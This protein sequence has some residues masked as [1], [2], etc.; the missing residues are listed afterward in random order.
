MA[1]SATIAVQRNDAWNTIGV[2]VDSDAQYRGR[3]VSITVGEGVG[4]AVRQC[5]TILQCIDRWVGIV[6]RVG[7][8][9]IAVQHQRAIGQ[10]WAGRSDRRG[11][12][13][14]ANGIIRQD[15]ACDSVG[16]RIFGNR[17]VVAHCSGRAIND[18][19]GQC[20]GIGA[21]TQ[22]IDYQSY[23][24]D[25]S[26]CRWLIER[27]VEGVVVGQR[28]S[29]RCVACQGECAFAGI[30]DNRNGAQ[31]AQLRNCHGG[32]SD[33]D[34]GQTIWRCYGDRSG[35][36]LAGVGNGK[37]TGLIHG[38]LTRCSP[39]SIRWNNARDTVCVAVD[40][41]G[42]RCRG[43]VTIAVGERIGVAVGECLAILEC[44]DRRQGVIQ[45]VGIASIT[46]Q[47]Q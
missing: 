4:I 16:R 25:A 17:S 30:D 5:L 12:G 11:I 18:L 15:R 6:Q 7:V 43:G 40:G 14:G 24:V 3:S 20:A 19:H 32:A 38:C 26:C 28:A 2:S 34:V 22:V 35:G 21:A 27:S 42:E 33:H 13:I 44:I 46:V 1:C 8:R 45:D 41:D 23:R 31:C 10:S 39:I 37:Q 29:S 47:H 9:A 36:C